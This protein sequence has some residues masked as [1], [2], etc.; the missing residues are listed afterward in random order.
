MAPSLFAL[1][2]EVFVLE[3]PLLSQQTVTEEETDMIKSG[4][5]NQR[6]SA[7]WSAARNAEYGVYVAKLQLGSAY[8]CWMSLYEISRETY[9]ALGTF[10]NDDYLSER[11]IRKGK[12][13]YKY[14]NERSC[15][16]PME[17]VKNDRYRELCAMLLDKT[18]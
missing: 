18:E 3:A 16:E 1:P 6:N 11:L 4:C 8:G 12:L 7:E 13:L 2:L 15:P 14:E 9:E 17:L 5:G 10:E